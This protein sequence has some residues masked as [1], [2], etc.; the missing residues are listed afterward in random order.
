MNI[1]GW[2]LIGA[3]MVIWFIWSVTLYG[4]ACGESEDEITEA[5]DDARLT[6][7]RNE[8]EAQTA[9]NRPHIRSST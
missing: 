8:L 7:I 1:I 5:E 3:A 9:P 6:T 4:L 2:L